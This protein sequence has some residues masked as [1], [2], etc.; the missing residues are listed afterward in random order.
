MHSRLSGHS[1]GG[2]L[3]AAGVRARPGSWRPRW[4]I[5]LASFPGPMRTEG[6]CV[7]PRTRAQSLT[8][9]CTRSL[10][11][12]ASAPV[13]AMQHAKRAR[14]RAPLSSR[15]RAHSCR[16][17]A[18]GPRVP[19]PRGALRH[20]RH[21]GR[22]LPGPQG[23]LPGAPAVGPVQLDRRGS[24]RVRPVAPGADPRVLRVAQPCVYL[25]GKPLLLSVTA[26][27][28]RPISYCEEQARV[29]L[30]VGTKLDCPG[31]KRAFGALKSR[32][33]EREDG[34]VPAFAVSSVTGDGV[35]DFQEALL[36]AAAEA[37]A[38]KRAAEAAAAGVGEDRDDSSG[39]RSS[40]PRGRRRA[41]PPPPL[42]AA[43]AGGDAD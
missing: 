26:L 24:V 11:M 29:A 21:C 34:G 7:R 36:R 3:R 35:A 39:S 15:L 23:G 18:T 22:P 33:A 30:C 42:A 37:A 43:A 1:S 38:R 41:H 10:P 32:L 5:S 20:A 40:P 25:R 27:T 19:P 2:W 12:P 6:W 8:L 4:L 13:V 31:A 9:S 14:F 28:R 17:A 16:A